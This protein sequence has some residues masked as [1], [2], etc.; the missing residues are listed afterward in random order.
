MKLIGILIPNRAQIA[1]I[2]LKDVKVLALQLQLGC[3]YRK[4]IAY[5]FTPNAKK[6]S[7]AKQ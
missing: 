5:T 2:A 3:C 6:L 7:D 4:Q 1:N